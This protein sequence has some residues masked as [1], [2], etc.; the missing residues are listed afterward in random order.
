MPVSS[1]AHPM[2]VTEQ[3]QWSEFGSTDIGLTAWRLPVLAILVLLL[4]RLPAMFVL[5]RW[6][7]D[8]HNRHEALF[9]GWFGPIGSVVRS[10]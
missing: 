2:I 10:E 7:P 8:V 3:M 9:T 4:K 6:I 1:K 5:Y